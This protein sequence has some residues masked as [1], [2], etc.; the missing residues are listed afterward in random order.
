MKD[1]SQVKFCQAE[2]GDPLE[3]SKALG[4]G[5]PTMQEELGPMNDSIEPKSS[6]KP[7]SEWMKNKLLLC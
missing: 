5:G 6:S 4:D 2:D 1:G 3:D 7:V